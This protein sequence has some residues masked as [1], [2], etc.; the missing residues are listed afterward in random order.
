MRLFSCKVSRMLRDG[1][2]FIFCFLWVFWAVSLIWDSD[3]NTTVLKLL[4][5]P[6]VTSSAT[7]INST[8]RGD[9]VGAEILRAS[10]GL[11]WEDHFFVSLCLWGTQE[12]RSIFIFKIFPLH[13]L[14]FHPFFLPRVKCWGLNLS[15][16]Q[17]QIWTGTPDFFPRGKTVSPTGWNLSSPGAI[18]EDWVLSQVQLFSVP[19]LKTTWTPRWI[20]AIRSTLGK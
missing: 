5:L 12:H 20:M 14:K 18:E 16:I 2:L 6:W 10:E 15:L 3:I 19:L 7:L 1:L 8:A 17:W 4:Y 9:G 13:T 11:E